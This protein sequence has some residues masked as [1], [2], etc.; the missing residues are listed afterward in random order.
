MTERKRTRA[1]ERAYAELELELWDLE[2][3]VKHSRRK[4]EFI[5]A[6]WHRIE[7]DVPVRR[8]KTR[9]TACIDTDVVKWFRAMGHGYQARMNRVLRIFMLAMVSK[10]ILNRANTDW[11]GDPI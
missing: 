10:E 2:R 6:D 3:E 11:K 5:P 4:R 9:I 7:R 1:E 8:R